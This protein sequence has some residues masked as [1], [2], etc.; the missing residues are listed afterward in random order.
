MSA[1]AFVY[2]LPVKAEEFFPDVLLSLCSADCRREG[3]PS[4]VFKL[5]YDPDDVGGNRALAERLVDRLVEGDYRVV[6]FER[7]WDTPVVADLRRRAA[8]PVTALLAGEIGCATPPEIDVVVRRNF[9]RSVAAIVRAARRGETVRVAPFADEPPDDELAWGCEH[10]LDHE[11]VNVDFAPRETRKT[12]LGNAGCPFAKDTRRNRFFAGLDLDAPGILR[13]GCA[14]CHMGGDYVRRDA[15]ASA[16]RV[17]AQVRWLQPRLPDLEEIQIYEQ[18]VLPYLE[19][20]VRRALDEGLRPVTWLFMDRADWI[21]KGRDELRRAVEV[22]RG[23]GFRIVCYLVGFESFSARDLE[24]LN[25]GVTPEE[26]VAAARFLRGLQAE[27]PDVF[28]VDRY[29]TH[30]FVLFHPWSEIEDIEENRRVMRAEGLG[31][32]RRRVT[33]TKLRLEPNL[34]LYARAAADGLLAEDFATPGHERAAVMGYGAEAPWRFRSV[35]TAR[36]FELCDALLRVLPV[37]REIP[38]LGAVLDLV[39]GAAD[40]AAID[41]TAVVRDVRRFVALLDAGGELP[42]GGLDAPEE[43]WETLRRPL[44]ARADSA[45]FHLGG[46]CNNACA[47]CTNHDEARESDFDRLVAAVRH[48]ATGRR[49]AIFAGREPTL[50]PRLRDLVAAARVAGFGEVEVVSNAR[51]F[52]W[53]PYARALAAAGLTRLRA[54]LLGPTATIAEAVSRSAGSFEQAL[55]GARAALDAGVAVEPLFVVGRDSLAELPRVIDVAQAL[56]VLRIEIEFP[57]DGVGLRDLRATA[58]RVAGVVAL[59][60]G[61]RLDVALQRLSAPPPIDESQPSR[62]WLRS[63]PP[64]VGD[65]RARERG[66]NG[67]GSVLDARG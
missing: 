56:G 20:L 61:R 31:S 7:L 65:A 27:A 25:K 50:H 10:D 40:P 11:I 55:A 60:R 58:A 46:P 47:T 62:L 44:P 14:F 48:A 57:L 67:S 29:P 39:R 21:L 15:A 24:L 35:A 13:A 3:I 26:N 51:R 33:A 19:L 16:E 34:P 63:A 59:A 37:E 23:T 49:R 52:A 36:A 28:S 43:V 38:L 64:A 9:R 18:H 4:R 17:L 53:M 32:L 42:P 2:A 30:G 45:L 66:R 54:K 22:C 41:V 12:V 1:V 5:Y 6:V 8:G